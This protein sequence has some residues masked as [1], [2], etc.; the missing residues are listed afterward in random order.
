MAFHSV[1]RLWGPVL[2]QGVGC[3]TISGAAGHRSTWHL[4][5]WLRRKR[6]EPG[7]ARMRAL[8]LLA[9]I[10]YRLQDDAQSTAFF[11]L[12]LTSS[13]WSCGADR[14]PLQALESY[15]DNGQAPRGRNRPGGPTILSLHQPQRRSGKKGL[16]PSPDCFLPARSQATAAD[17]NITATPSGHGKTS[18]EPAGVLWDIRCLPPCQCPSP[19][20]HCLLAPQPCTPSPT[21]VY[22]HLSLPSSTHT[23]PDQPFPDIPCP[24]HH[25]ATHPTHFYPKSQ[26]LSPRTGHIVLCVGGAC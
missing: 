8:G 17:L 3:F 24:V 10:W 19:T 22:C 13:W 11:A 7:Q 25:P 21:C 16:A 18:L 9:Q 12:C 5:L 26:A 23:C 2:Q 4:I 20:P 6:R 1:L 15:H 14:C